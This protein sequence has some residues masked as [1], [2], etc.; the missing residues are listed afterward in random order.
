MSA[1]EAAADEK[2][3]TIPGKDDEDLSLDNPQDV[4]KIKTE[5]RKQQRANAGLKGFRRTTAVRWAR[6]F[7]DK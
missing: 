4:K 5:A 3:Q 1:D 6:K 2:P 7:E